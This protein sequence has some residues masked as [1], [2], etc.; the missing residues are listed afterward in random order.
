MILWN[1]SNS[2]YKIKKG[3]E[4]FSLNQFGMERILVQLPQEDGSMRTLQ[5]AT[6]GE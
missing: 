2:L 6:Q 4:K 5:I 3:T 1:I